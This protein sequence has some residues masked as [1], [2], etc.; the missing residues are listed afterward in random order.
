M[1]LKEKILKLRATPFHPLSITEIAKKLKC[2][3]T[4][5]FQVIKQAREQKH[6]AG[7]QI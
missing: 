3:R 2:S 5:V 4:Y 7:R 1:T 6:L